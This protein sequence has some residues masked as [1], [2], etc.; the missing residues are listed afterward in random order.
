[1]IT[2]YRQVVL[3]ADKLLPVMHVLHDSMLFDTNLLNMFGGGTPLFRL[4]TDRFE[5]SVHQLLTDGSCYGYYEDDRLIGVILAFDYDAWCYSKRKVVNTLFAN[6]DDPGFCQKHSN[7]VRNFLDAQTTPTLYIW[8]LAV[9]P[10]YN[11]R[12]F[13][14]RL[15]TSM[16]A[17]FDETHCIIADMSTRGQNNVFI[18]KGFKLYHQSDAT[19]ARKLGVG[20]WM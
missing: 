5:S 6:E 2:Q 3:H 18:D 20:K 14:N 7:D 19:I 8:K 11:D 1:M 17:E 9:L 4:F 13:E 10:G 12:G 16:C 15:L